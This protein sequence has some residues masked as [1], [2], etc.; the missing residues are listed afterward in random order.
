MMR[1]KD[2]KILAKGL[3]RSGYSSRFVNFARLAA[4]ISVLL[5]TFALIISLSVLNGFESELRENAVRFSSHVT[6]FPF[7]GKPVNDSRNL[8]NKLKKSVPDISKIESVL[9]KEALISHG[10]EVEGIL[11]KSLTT[12]RYRF[13]EKEKDFI[14]FTSSDAREIMIGRRLADKMEL[15]AGDDVIIYI[16]NSVNTGE[17]PDPLIRKFRIKGVYETGMTKYDELIVYLPYRTAETFF[18]AMPGSCNKIEIWLSDISRVDSLLP[19]IGSLAGNDLVARSVFQLHAG[20]FAW[21]DLQKEPIPLVLGLISIVAV[22]NIL[23]TLLIIVVEKT[24]SIGILRALGMKRKELIALFVVQGTLIG[25]AGTLA[26][27]FLAFACWFLQDKFHLIRLNGDIYFLD[28][29]PIGFEPLHYIVIIGVSIILSL[30]ST[31]APSY[32]ASRISPLKAI[33]FR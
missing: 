31:L 33:R 30:I 5:G 1:F 16:V 12:N 13:G 17:I 28:T 29:L 14:E 24:H 23:T 6:I 15:T 8:V 4:F 10:D 2:L 21:I 27:A 18:R 20:I 11:V 19:V 9:E 7:F 22:M 32:I 26:G 3:A 25:T